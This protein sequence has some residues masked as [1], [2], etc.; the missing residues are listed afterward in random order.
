MFY[1]S[2]RQRP[3][4]APHPASGAGRR[5]CTRR[6]CSASRASSAAARCSTTSSPPTRT[7]QVEP[8]RRVR[9]EAADDG[10]HR[11]RLI[12]TGDVAPR[13]DAITGR[14]PLFFNNDVV[15]GVVPAGRA[16]ARDH[17]LPQRRSRRDAL[18]PRGHGRL[19]D[20][21]RAAALRPRRLHRHPDRHDLAPAPDAGVEQRMLW[22]ECPS[23][24][25]P[26]KRYRNEYGQL[27]EHAP[28]SQRDIRVARR[29]RRRARD[30]GEFGSTSRLAAGS[31]PTTTATTR[32]T[33]SAGTAI[34]GR[35]SSTSATSSRSPAAST[36]RRRCTRRSRRATS[37]SARSCPASSTTT[38]S[39]SRRRTTTPTSTA[40]RSSTTS[41]ATS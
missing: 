35:T 27:L 32:S 20:D 12:K 19:R 40:T 9:L 11:H 17:L 29:R 41:P 37:S 21:L 14:V 33:W 26:P 23:E 38:R 34:S 3:T 8:V 25:E 6:S 36:S 22:L 15:M 4:Q 39:P 16:D 7:H 31:P 18:R 2:A 13:G 30:E 10:V 1:V 24:I 5:A 28:Y